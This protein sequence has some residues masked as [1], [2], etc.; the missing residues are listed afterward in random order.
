MINSNLKATTNHCT[1]IKNV[2]LNKFQWN[3][4]SI[5]CLIAFTKLEN[6]LLKIVGI[7]KNIYISLCR[8]INIF[9]KYSN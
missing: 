8:F 2:V 1:A 9:K 6:T 7:K 3:K 5:L 4:L